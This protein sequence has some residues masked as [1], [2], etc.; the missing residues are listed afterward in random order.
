[1]EKKIFLLLKKLKNAESAQLCLF[2]QREKGPPEIINGPGFHFCNQPHPSPWW[3]LELEVGR[4]YFCSFLDRALN[5][6]LNFWNLEEKL[7]VLVFGNE[8][9][10]FRMNRLLWILQWSHQSTHDFKNFLEDIYQRR[11]L[12]IILRLICNLNL[13]N[14]QVEL[15]WNNIIWKKTLNW[16]DW[17]KHAK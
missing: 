7:K 9:I 14:I 3:N 12:R 11:I 5:E 15:N 10:L 2:R 6:K 4:L 13:K 17:S 16:K 8:W 1:M